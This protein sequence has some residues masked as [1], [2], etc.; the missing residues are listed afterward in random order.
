MT[1]YEELARFLA[2]AVQSCGGHIKVSRELL[3]NMS[4]VRLVWDATSEPE[5]ITLASIS[6][7]VIELTVTPK[8]DVDTDETLVVA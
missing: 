1:Q 3:D 7:E 8:S 2:F 6:N 4:P 5:S